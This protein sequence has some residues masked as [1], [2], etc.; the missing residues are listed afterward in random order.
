MPLVCFVR[1]LVEIS[2]SGAY[3]IE[4]LAVLAAIAGDFASLS[5][6][7]CAAVTSVSD[8]CAAKREQMGRSNQTSSSTVS[9]ARHM[10]RLLG[11]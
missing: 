8:H 7:T 4:D 6:V 10:L 5:A 9:H 11:A 1:G 2:K 3:W